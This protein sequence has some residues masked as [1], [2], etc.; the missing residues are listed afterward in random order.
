M[1]IELPGYREME[2]YSTYLGFPWEDLPPIPIELDDDFVWLLN[3]GVLYRDVSIRSHDRAYPPLSPDAVIDFARKLNIILPPSFR[4]FMTSSQIQSRLRSCTDCYLD[5]GERIV[6][7]VGAIPGYLI[8]F[9]SDSQSCVHWY[10]HVLRDSASAVLESPDLYCYSI[11]NSHWQ[12]NP[13]CRLEEIDLTGL[14]FAYCATSFSEFIYRFW[15]ENE[16]W[17]ALEVDEC[18]RPLSDLESNY[19]SHYARSNTL[20]EGDRDS[21]TD[22]SIGIARRTAKL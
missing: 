20:R 16:I 10:L 21:R 11:E 7:T 8:H 3:D 4:R 9:L 13:A 17:Y 19:V 6:E 1:H 12:E 18:R 14:D 5:P 15:I 22:D 2:T